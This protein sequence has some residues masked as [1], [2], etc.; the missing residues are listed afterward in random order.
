MRSLWRTE[1]SAGCRK[2][3]GGGQKRA[4]RY[5]NRTRRLPDGEGGGATP[6]TRA[7]GVVF[8]KRRIE[9]NDCAARRVCRDEWEE[10]RRRVRRA[11]RVGWRGAVRGRGTGGHAAGD[12]LDRARA[13]ELV[14]RL[15][16]WGGFR[17]ARTLNRICHWSYIC[18][19]LHDIVSD[20]ATAS[21]LE[22]CTI[23][24]PPKF[25]Y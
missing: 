12:H 5:L 18:M 17:G 9:G 2:R 25:P 10:M 20:I 13:V 22:E 23:L 4:D 24:Y 19:D 16:R 1:R 11:V 8:M 7:S 14:L 21:N 15:L 6:C 3:G